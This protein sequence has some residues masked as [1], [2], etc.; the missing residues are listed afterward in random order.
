MKS[1]LSSD[2]YPLIPEASAV[3]ALALTLVVSVI[4]LSI[5]LRSLRDLASHLYVL[6]PTIFKFIMAVTTALLWQKAS[7]QGELSQGLLLSYY[8]F[9]SIYRIFFAMSVV[10]GACRLE[11]LALP[12]YR[13]NK[14]LWIGLLISALLFITATFWRSNLALL[15]MIAYVSAMAAAIFILNARIVADSEARKAGHSSPSKAINRAQTSLFGFIVLLVIALAVLLVLTAVSAPSWTYVL[16]EDL[17]EL[18]LL[19]LWFIIHLFGSYLPCFSGFP[20][21]SSE[22]ST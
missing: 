15:S 8:L 2:L 14:P 9:S 16:I 20:D 19:S 17:F 13:I 3:A 6:L 5:Y 18:S 1:E 4:L 7:Q 22:L 12:P 21:H 11:A 10:F